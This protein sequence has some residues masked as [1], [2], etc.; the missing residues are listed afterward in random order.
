M[1]NHNLNAAKVALNVEKQKR[2]YSNSTFENYGIIVSAVSE[3]NQ[4]NEND[5]NKQDNTDEFIIDVQNMKKEDIVFIRLIADSNIPYKSL[6]SEAWHFFFNVMNPSYIIPSIKILR[7]YI[8]VNKN[9]NGSQYIL[10]LGLYCSISMLK[11]LKRNFYIQYS[12]LM[13]SVI[14]NYFHLKNH[15]SINYWEDVVIIM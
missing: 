12:Y 1:D 10:M 9:W 6:T 4:D 11:T 3:Y 7:K 8:I 5:D 13:I 14:Q 2:S 15:F